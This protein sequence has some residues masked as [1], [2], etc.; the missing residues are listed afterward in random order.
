MGRSDVVVIGGGIIG[1]TLACE[2][3]RL[4]AKDVVV[5]EAGEPGGQSTGRSSGG[6][7]R[8]FGNR[9]EIEMTLAGLRFYESVFADP[10]FDGVFAQVGYAFLCGPDSADELAR[11]WQLQQEVGLEVAWLDRPEP[12]E[13]FPY[14]NS[15]TLVGGT[16]CQD[17]G[18]VDPWSLC[19]SRSS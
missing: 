14:V 7:R 13:R 17:D 6:I 15:R 11:A 19:P 12:A 16:F 5:L 2:V 8:Q 10:Q 4:G 3:A 9:L 18:I 1:L